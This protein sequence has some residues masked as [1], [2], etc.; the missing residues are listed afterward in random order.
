MKEKLKKLR[1]K[2]ENFRKH[3]K[4]ASFFFIKNP[5]IEKLH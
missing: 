2:F 5:M 1:K 4:P 3:V